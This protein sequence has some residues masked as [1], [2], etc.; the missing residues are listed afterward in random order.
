MSKDEK[1]L[2]AMFIVFFLAASTVP[3]LLQPQMPAQA[4]VKIDPNLLE[5]MENENGPFTVLVKV[6]WHPNLEPIKFNHDA[7]ILELQAEAAETQAPVITY[8]NQKIDAEVL[9]TF[10]L[11]NIILVKAN[12]ETLIEL[13]TLTTVEAVLMNFNV[14]VPAQ[15]VG[16]EPSESAALT[17]NIAKVRAPEVWAM[18]ITGE[19]IK[20]ATTDTGLEIDHPDLIGTLFTADPTD[21]KYPGGWIEYDA[22]GKEIWSTPHDT[23]GHGTAT[24][25]LI[26]GDAAGPYGAVGM[27]PGAKGLGMHAL[28]LPEGGGQWAQ[29]LAGLQWVLKPY[30]EKGR[31]YPM[32][33]VSSHSWGATGYNCYL[34][35]AVENMYQAGHL[36]VASIGNSYEGSS[37]TP[38]NY[39]SVFGVGA[40]NINDYVAAFSSGEWVYK[41]DYPCTVPAWW[42]DKW[43]KP[44]VSAP[45][46]AVIVP[47][48]GK[49]WRYW[50]GTSFSSPHV[51]GAAVL[52][53]SGNPTLTP[54]EIKEALQD[55]AV[56]YNYYYPSR[57]D[58]RYGWGRIDAY[59]AVMRVALPQGIRGYVTDASTGAPIEKA[60]VS[61]A[62]RSVE[63]DA[64]GY[65][66]MRLLPST[67]DVTFSR[68]GYG[69]ATVTGVLVEKDKFTWLNASLTPVPP[70]YVAGHVYFEPTQIGIPGALVQALDVPVPIQ[71][72]TNADGYYSL[73]I[74]PGTYDFMA[75]AYGFSSVT[76]KG[77]VVVQGETTTVDFNL[78]QP[79]ALAVVG[80]QGTKIKDFLKGKGYTIVDSYATIAAVIPNVPMYSTIIVNVPGSTAKDTL[81]SFISAT[82]ANGVGVVWHDQWYGYTGARLLYMHLGWPPYRYTAYSTTWAHTYYRVTAT[83]AD[84]VPG[85][86]VGYKII[87]D[88]TSTYKM[89]ARWTGIVDGYKSGIGTVKIVA[90]PGYN[91]AGKDYD[92]TGNQG[93]VKVTRDAGNKWVLLSMHGNTPY[94]DVIHWQPDTQKVFINSVNWVA[95]P[96]VGIPK[97]VEWN[98]TVEPKVTMWKYPVE[99]SVGIKN[100]GWTTG[101]HTVKMYVDTILEGT[102]TVTLAPGEYTHPSWTV[103]RFDVGTY[104]VRVQHLS[105]TFKVRPP[106][107]T[108]HAYEFSTDQ[109]LA[110]ADVYGYYR[111]YVGPGWFTQW[112]YNY[113]GYGHSQHAQPVGD[114]DED[115][116]NEIIVGG[117]ETTGMCRILSYSA[118]L[119]TYVEEYSWYVP[120]GSYHSPSGSTV[121]DLDE[122]GD[123]EFVVSWTYSGADG[124][125]AYD[126]DGKT[127][128]ELDYYACGFVFDVYSCDY[129]DDGYKELLI[130]NAPWGPTDYHVMAFGWDK[131]TNKFVVEASWKYAGYEWECMM[132]WSGDTDNDGKTEVI[133]S[134]SDSYYS[135]L[136]TWA[137]NWDGSKW[138]AEPVYTAYLDGGTHYGVV[139]GDINGNGIPEIGIGSND[140]P[141]VGDYKGASAVLVEWTGSAY[142]KVWGQSWTGP[143]DYATIEALAIGDPD[144]DGKNEFAV[145]SGDNVHI[146]GWTGSAYAE[147]STI[148]ATGGLMSGVVIGDMDTDGKNELKACN[149]LTFQGYEWIFKYSP[150]P[151]PLPRWEFKY[152]GKTD[153]DGMLVFD[154]P[155]SVVDMYLFV[156]KPEKTALGYQYLLEKDMMINNDVTITYKPTTATESVVKAYPEESALK[157]FDHLAI[158]WLWKLEVPVMWPFPTWYSGRGNPLATNIVVAPSAYSF[159][160][161]LYI[162]DAWGTWAYYMLNPNNRVKYLPAGTTYKYGFAGPLS[163]YVSS[164]QVDTTVT[165][166]WDVT[167]SKG[168]QI[169]GV[170]LDEAGSLA[171]QSSPMPTSFKPAIFEEYKAVIAA[172][173]EHKPLITLYDAQSKIVKTGYVEWHQKTIAVPVD[174]AV[175]YATLRFKAGPYGDP[176]PEEIVWWIKEPYP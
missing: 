104:T 117:Y 131:T 158:V 159:M 12:E 67:Y 116:V 135:T 25:G 119:G 69:S 126:W 165:V 133:A 103:S 11:S 132:I 5:Q 156:Y 46:E 113:G 110:Y 32:P 24:Y 84:I 40:T 127:L 124:I 79:P 53:L 155:A 108:L 102:T 38:G 17:W 44:E 1:K 89:L 174:G 129:D 168:H 64:K 52:M 139:V 3:M 145:S 152:F 167:D 55:T 176:A 170:V 111:K 36:C 76:V 109:P 2:L 147:E 51:A 15:E 125:Y 63:T 144:N 45:G 86:P 21:P 28:S 169:T 34:I 81:L 173:I 148:T 33:R 20:F 138:V 91:Y 85:W 80:D 66:D 47:Y 73:E 118:A 157:Q 65:Y 72:E 128:T 95:K 7:V 50:D 92:Y 130:A 121:L 143:D 39:Y 68:F 6:K 93:I 98:L 59:E 115:G 171:S 43:I 48:W 149:I 94:I 70:G 112:S 90:L 175:A 122:D 60:T 123:L 62:G 26:V 140:L 71:A 22:N 137:L 31:Y 106:Q 164:D 78:A 172:E 107:I 35:D 153:A 16:S 163:G 18:G 160:H 61:A 161:E 42:P 100:V 166:N 54:D 57:P 114:I 162:A 120:G 30:D 105:T 146:I 4:L 49:T 82:D 142:T 97:F 99:V 77:V 74:P 87:H 14:T 150:V 101:T 8:L 41:T 58:T 96:H 13:A 56:W 10:W 88:K 134:I 154:S 29:V 27:A 19:G 23:M 136:G 141:P 9:N 83:D 37:G 151:T 75:S